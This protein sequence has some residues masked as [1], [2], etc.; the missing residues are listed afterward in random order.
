MAQ[1]ERKR[2]VKKKNNFEA[3]WIG[4]VL[5]E[6]PV[7]EIMKKF[8]LAEQFQKQML[9]AGHSFDDEK[10]SQ[11]FKKTT[12]FSVEDVM[13]EESSENED[14]SCRSMKK[15]RKQSALNSS[16]S[17]CYT[18]AISCDSREKICICEE[19]NIF[20]LQSDFFT[21]FFG[22]LINSSYETT[23]ELVISA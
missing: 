21:Q 2:K 7:E 6:E 3:L 22:V 5:D 16:F 12:N 23:D 9:D 8:Q 11:L 19:R 14:D 1:K 10:W 15:K 18:P 13:C 20:E 17:L 4:Y